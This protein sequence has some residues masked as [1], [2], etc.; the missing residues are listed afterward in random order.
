VIHRET[1]LNGF[2]WVTS[3]WELSIG[4]DEDLTYW[5]QTISNDAPK[6]IDFTRYD[7]PAQKPQVLQREWSL[8]NVI[9][10]KGTRPQDKP[11]PLSQLSSDDQH[12]IFARYPALKK[13]Q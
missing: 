4:H 3:I 6:V 13:L 2:G 8:M 10:Q 11:M 12:R 5:L 7:L 9:N 1:A